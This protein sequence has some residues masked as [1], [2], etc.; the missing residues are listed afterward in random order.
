MTNLD[1]TDACDYLCAHVTEGERDTPTI[2]AFQARLIIQAIAPA[3]G[4]SD[5]ELETK[6]ASY[7]R[8]F[9]AV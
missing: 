1:H 2:T 7:W 8:T 6:L 3:I 9:P 5:E 4:I